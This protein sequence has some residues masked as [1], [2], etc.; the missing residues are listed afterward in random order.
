MGNEELKEPAADPETTAQAEKERRLKEIRK[1]NRK[2]VRSFFKDFKAFILR[3]NIMNLAVAVVIGAAFTAIIN[4]LVGGIVMPFIALIPGQDGL[5]GMEWVL[6]AGD[7][8]GVGRIAVKWGDF[9][10]SILNF[11]LV[12]F[13]VFFIIRMLMNAEKGIN[14]LSKAQKA[15]LKELRKHPELAE[16][17]PEELQE[18]A[19]PLKV[20]TVEDILKDIRE[21]LSKQQA[22]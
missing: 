9:L 17:A 19:A 1:R 15:R 22:E 14:K 16:S 8:D 12:A 4:A 21:L 18:A 7:A 5:A 10:Q 6:R 13:A 3:G 11:L 20:E 2:R